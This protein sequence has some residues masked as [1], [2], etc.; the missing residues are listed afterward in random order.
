MARV[1]VYPWLLW[2]VGDKEELDRTGDD[3]D[4]GTDTLQGTLPGDPQLCN[5][6]QL[7]ACNILSVALSLKSLRTFFFIFPKYISFVES[8]S[9]LCI[10]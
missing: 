8:T 3:I 9:T 7:A 4:R 6:L 10:F 5:A 2:W 1:W